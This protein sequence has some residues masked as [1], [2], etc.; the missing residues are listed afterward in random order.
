MAS[1]DLAVQLTERR[2]VDERAGGIEGD[3]ADL[4]GAHPV[5]GP[6]LASLAV[7]G[8]QRRGEDRRILV[9][10][11]A[12]SGWLVLLMTGQALGGAVHLLLAAAL[13]AFPWRRLRG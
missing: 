1:Q 13:V 9:S 10:F 7:S 6:V 3:G 11:V 2:T 8:E 12:V 4:G 5:D